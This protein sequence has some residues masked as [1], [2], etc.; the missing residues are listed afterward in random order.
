MSRSWRGVG[1]ESGSTLKDYW[2][3]VHV[4]TAPKR[5]YSKQIEYQRR[6]YAKCQAAK[7]RACAHC[8]AEFI[9]SKGVGFR[10]CSAL[11]S[12][13]AKKDRDNARPPLSKE[14]SRRY[15]SKYRERN[16]TRCRQANNESKRKAR[17]E[18]GRGDRTAE[19]AARAAK[20]GSTYIGRDQAA[21]NRAE[22]KTADD[23]AKATRAAERAR[24]KETKLSEGDKWKLRY[25]TDPVFRQVE[26]QRLKAAKLKRK[27]TMASGL[28]A[29]QT[30]A[31]YAERS[32]C[33]YC[34]CALSEKEKVLEHM[35][36]IARG[37]AHEAHNL[38]VA[39]RKCNTKKSAKPFAEWLKMVVTERRSLVA[40][41]YARKKCGVDT[42]SPIVTGPVRYAT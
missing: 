42:L 5:E 33:L 35:D 18:R 27:K 11:H 36:P 22:R 32:T 1:C 15:Q 4:N 20:N 8:G 25:H 28:N 16:L 21:I 19:Y 17:A 31:L 34:G 13:Q 14:D 37:G 30:L 6:Y 2:R 38:T 41:E 39:C 26:I 23:A 29:K 7:A 3:G 9:P 12:A 10:Y 24:R 40:N